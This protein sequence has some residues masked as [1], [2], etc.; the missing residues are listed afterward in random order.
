M[1]NEIPAIVQPKQPR[2]R[3]SRIACN[4]DDTPLGVAVYL[5]AEELSEF[6]MDPEVADAVELT[7]QDGEISL[8]TISWGQS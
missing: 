1:R 3:E 4:S 6:G 7:V 8:T 2:G 5:T